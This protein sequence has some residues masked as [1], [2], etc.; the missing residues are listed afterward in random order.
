MNVTP[1][2]IS[3]NEQAQVLAQEE[4]DRIKS[5]MIQTQRKQAKTVERV[6]LLR[7][8]LTELAAQLVLGRV[9]ASAVDEHIAKIEKL[10]QQATVF[11]FALTGLE[12]IYQAAIDARNQAARTLSDNRNWKRFWDLKAQLLEQYDRELLHEA[13]QKALGIGYHSLAMDEYGKMVN[14]L[15]KIHPPNCNIQW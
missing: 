7:E 6:T 2:M 9:E 13:K 15:K 10:K 4:V 3:E 12:P 8:E 11:K 1:M 5:T 14:E